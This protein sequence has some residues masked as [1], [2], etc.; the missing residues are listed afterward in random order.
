MAR[1]RNKEHQGLPARWRWKEGAYRYLVPKGQED[2]WDN[3]TEFRLGAS[4]SEAHRTFAGRIA[5]SEGVVKT[6][7]QLLDRYLFE[8]TPTKG[9]RTQKDEVIYLARLRELI[10]QNGVTDFEPH[11]AYRL[12]DMLKALVKNMPIGTWRY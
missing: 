6:F 12:R 1:Q 9:K 3:K 10:H 8:V 11:H 7:G 4:Q 2:K 5:A